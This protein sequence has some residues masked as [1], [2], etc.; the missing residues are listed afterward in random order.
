MVQFDTHY[1][2]IA[3]PTASGKSSLAIALAKRLDAVIINAD[4]MQIYA[5]LNVLTA[6]PPQPDLDSAPHR[7]YGV[8]D[9]SA[10]CSVAHWLTLAASEVAQARI[11]KKL[12]IL[13]GGT[14]LY[15]NA[16]MKGISP[17]PDVPAQLVAEIEAELA[18]M[19]GP[20]FK[21]RLRQLDP[22]LGDKLE[23]G[24][25]QRLVRAMA[26]VRATSTPLSVWQK[27]PGEGQ[28][29]GKPLRIAVTPPRDVVYQAI[30]RRFDEMMKQ[31]AVDEVKTLLA[32]QLDPS[33]PA[34]KAL[35]V[36]A[37]EAHLAGE[38]TLER[39]V[40]L[41]QRDS[42]HYAKRQLT[43]LRNNF[44]SDIQVNQKLSNDEFDNFF[45]KIINFT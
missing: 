11:E 3:G 17:I 41:A 9:A 21:E 5:D 38:I 26:V 37:I 12:P 43:W 4:S 40:Y 1:L 19:G 16:A 20:A 25:S 44:I 8:M 33:L 35:G 22:E 36:R 7:L 18:E 29:S 42:R 13:V 23:A 28:L 45:S 2:V 6:R 24:D 34:M 30:D 27:Q 15:L 31:G 14:G 39:A 10:R 32:R